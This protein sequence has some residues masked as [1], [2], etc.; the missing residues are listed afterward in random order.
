MGVRS[1][2]IPLLTTLAALALTAPAAGGEL[3]SRDAGW[4]RELRVGVLAH[5]VDGLW[6]GSRAE[7]GVDYN[8][9]LCLR[10]PSFRFLSGEVTPNLGISVNNRGHTSKLYVGFLWWH[11]YDSGVF[12]NLGLG[13]AVHDGERETNRDDRKELGS[14]VLFRV[15]V[16]V[17][18]RLGERHS[19][20]L[21]FDHISNAG[22]A[23]ENEGLDTL[24]LRWGYSF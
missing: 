7:S 23:D 9:E 10:R 18:V 8:L 24:G 20:S 19:L 3:D 1:S 17:G 5:D 12:L 4:L 15:P 6:S 2:P 13:L 16:E 22:L 11:L 21:A 14:R